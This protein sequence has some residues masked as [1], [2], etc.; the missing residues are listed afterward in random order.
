M[1]L[2]AIAC[3]DKPPSKRRVYAR[4]GGR[5]SS[6][7]NDRL[8]AGRRLAGR[9]A[10]RSALDPVVLGMPRGGVPVAAEVASVLGAPLDIIVVRKIGCPWQPELGIGALAEGNVRVLN[11]A[12]VDELGVPP[13]AV[14]SATVREREELERRV[15]RYRD[16]RPPI[17]VAERVVIL[18]DDGLATGYTARAA[19]E[20]LRRRGARRV[21]LAVP[22]APREQQ[23][24][25]SGVV[26]ELVV[27]DTPTWFFAIG[28]H[29]RDFSQTSD[30]EVISL[31]ER[32]SATAGR[33][34]ARRSVNHGREPGRTP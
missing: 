32:G 26:D 29:Y 3:L 17:P 27:L 30:D 24:A 20:A 10:D 7:F 22:V 12:L 25:L 1:A 31:L 9:L 28:E 19:I 6:V 4:R 23:T 15:R 13:D 33:P 8:D 5:V 2:A 18:V 14:E 34:A 11:Q 21:I 16:D